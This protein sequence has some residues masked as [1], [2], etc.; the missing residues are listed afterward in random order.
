MSDTIKCKLC[1]EIV[2]RTNANQS[3]CKKCS[4]IHKR[5]WATQYYFAR[6]AV[7]PKPAMQSLNKIA[8]EARSLGLTYGKYVAL[9]NNG[10]LD[11]YLKHMKR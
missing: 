11:D 10:G 3:Y 9:L 8:A 6:K 7:P 2:E 5:Q 1:G 4:D